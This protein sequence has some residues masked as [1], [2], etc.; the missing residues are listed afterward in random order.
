MR[1][2]WVLLLLL[3]SCAGPAPAQRAVARTEETT[4]AGCHAAETREWSESMH[5]A[6]FTSADFQAS[7][8]GEPRAYCIDCHAP[9]RALGVAGT[10]VGIGCAECHG[11]LEAHLSAPT[12]HPTTKS[13]APCHDFPVPNNFAVLQMT[14]QEHAAS[15]FANVGCAECHLPKQAGHRDHRFASSRDRQRLA[16]ALSVAP[17][18]H[19]AEHVEVELRTRGVGHRFPTGDLYRRVT[20][21]LTATD[22]AEHIVCDRVVTLSRDWPEHER[23][24]RAR[25][26]E[27]FAGDTRLGPEPMRIAVP[28]AAAPIRLRVHVDYARGAAAHGDAFVAFEEIELLDLSFELGK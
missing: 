15:E 6:A 4:C 8:R 20:V 5:H 10:Q 16:D 9:R 18:G 27:S 28:C 12:H 25:D 11:E 1:G 21:T 24:I 3:V 22:A 19:D 2:L 14:E 7:W 13:C 23:S 17:L 26:A